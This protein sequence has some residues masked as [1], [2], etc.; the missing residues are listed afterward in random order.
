MEPKSTFTVKELL[1]RQKYPV[2]PTS[3]LTLF[4]TVLEDEAGRRLFVYA[5][6]NRLPEAFE[7]DGKP[8]S[9]SR[10]PFTTEEA[11]FEK[12]AYVLELCGEATSAAACQ[13]TARAATGLKVCTIYIN[14]VPVQVTCPPFTC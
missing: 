4:A 6:G 9:V 13:C 10:T 5:D 12:Q 2:D 7:H 11:P 3:G 1:W 14:G 8:I